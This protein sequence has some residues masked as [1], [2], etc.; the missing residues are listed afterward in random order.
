M[1][2]GKWPVKISFLTDKKACDW[3]GFVVNGVDNN[4]RDLGIECGVF[5]TLPV[6]LILC[7][8]RLLLGVSLVLTFPSQQHSWRDDSLGTGTS[9]H[10]STLRG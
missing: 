6:K 8:C 7:K 10:A 1:D 9:F 4:F 2:G 3:T 5:N